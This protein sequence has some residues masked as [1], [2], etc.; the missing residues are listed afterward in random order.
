MKYCRVVI[1][2]PSKGRLYKKDFDAQNVFG[3]LVRVYTSQLAAQ[4]VIKEGD[5]YYA[6][7]TPRYED[8]MLQNPIVHVNKAAMNERR[9]SWIDLEFDRNAAEPDRPLTFFTL[10]L[11]FPDSGLIYSHDL[12]ILIL[13]H[14]WSNLQTALMR[15]QVLK[16]GDLYIPRLYVRDDDEGD[17]ETEEAAL[18]RVEDDEPLIEL[19]TL[20]DAG[21]QFPLR[22]PND[23][24][25]TET[26]L[27]DVISPVELAAVDLENQD[28][29]QVFIAQDTLERLQAIA[30]ADVQIEQ[31]GVLVG[32]VYQNSRASS[33]YL[34]EITDFIAAENA[35]ANLV[36]LRYNFD[37]WLQQTTVLR[38]RFPGKQIVGWYH[39]HLIQ[40]P[41]AA[42]DEGNAL[43]TTELF[44][45]QDD[46]FMH[47]RF[48]GDR[49]YVAMVLGTPGNVGFFRWFGSKISANRGFFITLP[50]SR[51]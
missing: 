7:I 34:V 23:F 17:L 16:D 29:V 39:T 5:H 25:I 24:R 3:P 10:E 37:S 42:D 31:G 47:R 40:A 20:D 36:E 49:W 2:S 9:A 44:F 6:I 41:V 51:S 28:D 32:Q 45:S 30:R 22:S 46:R 48:F 43:Q 19:I 11:R 35:S 21:A 4:G 26:R 14:L 27:I 13:D 38:E 12:Q 8:T 15:M 50:D 1:H 33:Q 18:D